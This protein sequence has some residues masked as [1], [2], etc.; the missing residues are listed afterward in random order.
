MVQR[1]G[2]GA[3][4]FGPRHVGVG[5]DAA[6][7]FGVAREPVLLEPAD[8]AQ[9]PQRRIELGPPRHRERRQRAPPGVEG[10]ERVGA[11]RAQRAGERG[12]AG[13]ARSLGDGRIGIEHAR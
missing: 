7:A 9:L 1:I 10:R 2:A 8:M 5:G 3:H 4:A 12:A 6:R 11:A 13:A